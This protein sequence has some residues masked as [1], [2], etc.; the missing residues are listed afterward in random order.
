MNITII[1]TGYVGIFT[2]ACL[3]DLAKLAEQVGVDIDLVEQFHYKPAMTAKDGIQRFMDW[4]FDFY[5]Q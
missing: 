5:V 4:Y 1:D 2:G 3:A